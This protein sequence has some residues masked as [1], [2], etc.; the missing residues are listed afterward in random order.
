LFL[1]HF[2]R[3]HYHLV[4]LHF[5]QWFVFV[6]LIFFRYDHWLI[7]SQ[8][9]LFSFLFEIFLISNKITKSKWKNQKI[10]KSYLAFFIF[11]FR[12]GFTNEKRHCF[13]FY[14]NI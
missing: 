4:F 10:N 1:P 2:H 8:F 7:R 9:L 5:H 11:R 3:D 14:I 12:I 13:I 6:S